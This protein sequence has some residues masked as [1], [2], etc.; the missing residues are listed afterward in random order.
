MRL[1]LLSSV[2]FLSGC[3]S[4]INGSQQDLTIK[5]HKDAEIFINDRFAGRGYVSKAVDRAQAHEIRVERDDCQQLY[6]TEARFNKTSLLGLF[7]DLGLV[8]VPTD[9]L[10]G[11]A[12]EIYPN[13]IQIQSD[14]E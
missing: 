8:S 11:A 3:A 14:C 4:L 7:V 1:I 9:F 13:R 6:T 12:W 2:I 5:A 10:T